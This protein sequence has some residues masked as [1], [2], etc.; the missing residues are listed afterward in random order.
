MA[1][2]C[3]GDCSSSRV[4]FGGDDCSGCGDERAM[5]D[6]VAEEPALLAGTPVRLYRLRTAK[7]RNPLYGEPSQDGKEWSFDGPWEVFATMEMQDTEYQATD[8]GKK[9]SKSAT[10]YIPRTEVERAGAP[11]PKIG[12]V[13][14]MWAKKDYRDFGE[15]SGK[16]QW[17]VKGVSDDG[18]IFSSP[19][20]VQYKLTIIIREEFLAFRKTKETSI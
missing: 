14:E 9:T 16:T 10:M 15:P 1:G 3:K 2:F 4:V 18:R 19:T 8:A 17:D 13:V 7:N 6:S 12:D 20:F 5:F 11:E